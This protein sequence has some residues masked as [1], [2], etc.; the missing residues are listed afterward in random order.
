VTGRHQR[1]EELIER[2]SVGRAE[3]LQLCLGRHPGHRGVFVPLGLQRLSVRFQPALH[4]LDLRLLGGGDPC[5]DPFRL[6][7]PGA[8]RASSVITGAWAWCSI[9]MRAQETSAELGESFSACWSAASS[10]DGPPA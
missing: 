4:G 2:L 3:L 7:R 5:G 1:Q 6:R 8:L 10:A 9:I